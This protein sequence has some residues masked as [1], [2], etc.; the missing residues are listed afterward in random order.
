MHS[1]SAD[2]EVTDFQA[3][4]VSGLKVCISLILRVIDELGCNGD[5]Q[6]FL[7]TFQMIKVFIESMKSDLI[8][9]GCRIGINK[10]G[11]SGKC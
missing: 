2:F 4:S 11:G 7:N 5:S 3:G 1:G 10:A 6:P 8:A 9:P